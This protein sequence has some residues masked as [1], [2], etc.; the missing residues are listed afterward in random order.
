LLEFLTRAIMEEKEIKGIQIRKAE[1]KLF[2][3]ADDMI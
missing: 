2:L 1:F 3:F